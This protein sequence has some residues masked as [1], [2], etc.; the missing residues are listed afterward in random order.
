MEGFSGMNED[1][2]GAPR[3]RLRAEVKVSHPHAGEIRSHTRDISDSGAFIVTHGE[4]IAIGDVV[5]VQVQG[6][7]GGDAPVVRMR[8]VRLDK[9]GMGLE[10]VAR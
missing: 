10:F 2:R 7:P 3:T 9:D 6:L 1:S 5:E 4:T 8:I